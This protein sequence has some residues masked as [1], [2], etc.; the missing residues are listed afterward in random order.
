MVFER[1]KTIMTH[2]RQKWFVMN[3]FRNR[4]FRLRYEDSLADLSRCCRAVFLVRVVG[5]RTLEISLNLK[6]VHI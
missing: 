1:N 6:Q 3:L 2:D 4:T 5:T